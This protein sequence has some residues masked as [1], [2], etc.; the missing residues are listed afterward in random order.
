MPL[1][2][3]SR[4]GRA[5]LGK[6]FGDRV[7]DLT[8]AAP[9]LPATIKAFLEA[10]ET[11]VEAFHAVEDSPVAFALGDIELLPPVPNPE[12]YLAIGMN[13]REH[14]AEAK[15]AGVDTPPYQLWFNKQ[16]SCIVGPYDNVIKPDVS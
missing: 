15:E 13:Y 14:V 6:V 2:H 4:D 9:E 10:G 11:A 1:A 8:V 12:K 16:V 7:V 3:F 5:R